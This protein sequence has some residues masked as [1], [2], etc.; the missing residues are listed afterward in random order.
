MGRKK[1]K[2]KDRVDFKFLGEPL[3]GII[4]EIKENQ[5]YTTKDKIRY[6]IYDGRY[7]YPVQLENIIKKIK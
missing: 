1:Y 3:T 6:S 7:T 5:K 2:V 4:K